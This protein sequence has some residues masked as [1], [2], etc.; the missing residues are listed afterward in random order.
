MKYTIFDP[1]TR[2]QRADAA[3][4]RGVNAPRVPTIGDVIA[5]R[6]SR[7][8]IMKGAL[9]FTAIAA[10]VSPVAFAA[11]RAR[12]QGAGSFD[13]EEIEAT[14]TADHAVAPGHD[15]DI[16]IRWG[17][18][19]TAD[20]PEF[21]PANQT[22]E[23]QSKQFGY[24]NDYIGTVPHPDAPDD[25]NRLLMVVNHE[26]TNEELMFPGLGL[27]DEPTLDDAGNEVAPA[28]SGMTAELVEIEMNAHG[29]TVIEIARGADGKWSTVT[30]SPYNRRI[31]LS[32]PMRI[33]GPAAGHPKMQTN[34]DATGTQALGT[35]NNC[36]GG[37][38]PWGTWLMAEE[39]FNG[40][41]WGEDEAASDQEGLEDD[42]AKVLYARYGVPGNWYAW[43]RFHDRFDVS[44]EPLEPNR[45]G[46]IVE[47]DPSDP[48]STPVKRT[49]LGRFKHEGA[50]AVVNADGRVVLFLGDDERFDYVYRFV[51][52]Q[53]HDPANPNPDLLDEGTL[54]VA[55]FEEDGSVTW[56]PLVHGEGP[57]M[58]ENGFEDQGDVLI[59]ARRAGD[60]LEATPMD[61]PEDVEPN[62]ERGT[63][64]V[65]LTNNTRRKPG[66]ENP[67]NP[68][69][70]NVFGHIVEI[71]APEGDFAAD[72][73]RW[74]ILVRCGDPSVAEVGATFAPGT[75][76]NGW[77]GM[78]DNCA[79]D[80]E[81]RLW[82]A[83]DGN[84]FEDSGRADGIWA[85]GTEGEERGL[86]RH[87]Y[88]VPVGAEM[89]GPRFTE[90][91]DTLFVAVQH[92]GDGGQEWPE[93][94]R[95]STFEDPSTRWPD[96]QDGTP[97]RPSVV[98]ITK[99]GGGRI[100]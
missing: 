93:F 53:A 43:G 9:G 40:Y 21:D 28:F 31:M 100:G 95:T 99:Q 35:V 49:A 32:T 14:V 47:V 68:R 59:Q 20:A 90:A 79:V 61:R 86:S 7:R 57:L 46:W 16:L 30:D 72:T 52:A 26:Y 83:T 58:A 78:P 89:C 50:E 77:F 33:A 11:G 71:T 25:P 54:S 5:T 15:A 23:A 17:D 37:I 97:P 94:G 2:S 88:R 70:E 91:G 44:K 81:G 42:P 63:V 69:P 22:A 36:A 64:Y 62:P 74:D 51:T 65:M 34:A 87:F 10:T 80:A 41:F 27:Q 66:D 92:P 39:N 29:G 6:M 13:F 60:F 76:E 55:R 84:S 85:L 24:N 1:E 73:M 98:S 48:S 18:P 56:M 67:A 4:D 75:T 45:F 3:D 82:I 19:V 96:F 38:T 8:D 12:A